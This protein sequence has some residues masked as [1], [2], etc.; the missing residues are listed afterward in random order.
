M[1]N[2][3]EIMELDIEEIIKAAREAAT[4]RSKDWILKQIKGLGTNKGKTQEERNDNGANGAALESEEPQT[5]AKK[6]QRNTSRSTKKGDKREAGHP[7]EAA[8]PGSSKKAKV[9]NGEQISMIVQECL[10]SMAPL[11]FVKAGGCMRQKDLGTQNAGT[12]KA[13]A[14]QRGEGQGHL[15]QKQRASEAHHLLAGGRRQLLKTLQ[16]DQPRYGA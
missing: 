3:G 13:P 14:G 16:Q 1:E 11:L 8:T 12:T 4:T 5:E 2:S 9:N 15:E 6:R 7:R 10:K